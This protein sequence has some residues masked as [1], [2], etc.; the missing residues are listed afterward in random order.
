[1]NDEREPTAMA[2]TILGAYLTGAYMGKA[3]AEQLAQHLAK[4]IEIKVEPKVELVP[5]GT[6][7]LDK[8]NYTVTNYYHLT[9]PENQST[10]YLSENEGRL[11]E[12]TIRS[13]STNFRIKLFVDDVE[14]LNQTYTDL[15]ALSPHTEILDAYQETEG[16]NYVLHI[17][18]VIWTEKIQVIL[19]AEGAPINFQHIWAVWEEKKK[20]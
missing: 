16:G 2:R 3:V 12:I 9:P 17:K 20:D 8:R 18:D 14:K 6:K 19:Y 4:P 10:L 7:T 15:T 13:P 1:M 11:K 5:F